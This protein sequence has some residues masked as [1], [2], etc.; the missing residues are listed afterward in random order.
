MIRGLKDDERLP[1]W[2]RNECNR[3]S[4]VVTTLA[5][6]RPPARYGDQAKKI[7]PSELF[8]RSDARKAVEDAKSVYELSERFVRWWFERVKGARK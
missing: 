2:F 3:A 5:R 4:E 6:L 1:R 8:S 7:P